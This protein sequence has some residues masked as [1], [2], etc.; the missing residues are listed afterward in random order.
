M[1]SK[2]AFKLYGEY[3][4]NID[5]EK[6]ERLLNSD[7]MLYRHTIMN[8]VL[9]DIQDKKG[10]YSDVRTA[11]EWY[12]IGR[13]VD[14][15][16]KLINLLNTSNCTIYVDVNTNKPITKMELSSDEIQIALNTGIIKKSE[17]VVRTNIVLGY[18]VSNTYEFEQN[19]YINRIKPSLAAIN[20]WMYR[21]YKTKFTYSNTDNCNEV[22]INKENID[23]VI[24]TIIYTIENITNTNKE[25]I[26]YALGTIFGVKYS[27][28][29]EHSID[30]ISNV[31]D[32]LRS[33][34]DEHL[35]L[36]GYIAQANE[37]ISK[38]EES[39]RMLDIVNYISAYSKMG[40]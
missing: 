35:I 19:K 36:Y 38:I 30:D 25:L 21:E 18:D 16:K 9:I 40:G 39:K 23:S 7:S 22:H 33:M 5:S 4:N 10:E 12:L 34:L 15:T 1:K 37:N 27:I 14:D 32:V 8:R 26:R 6:I 3:I 24:K 20:R 17:K 31:Q 11:E 2:D 28:D 29:G 13:K